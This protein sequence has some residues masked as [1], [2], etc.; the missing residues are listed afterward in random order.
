MGGPAAGGRGGSGGRARRAGGPAADG[1][2]GHRRRGGR[3]NSVPREPGRRLHYRYR[4]GR[5]RWDERSAGTP[6]VVSVGDARVKRTAAESSGGGAV[7][8]SGSRRLG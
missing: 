1:P 2:A 4:P 8:S 7:R 5:G 3:R 6:T